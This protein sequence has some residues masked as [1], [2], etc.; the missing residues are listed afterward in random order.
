[1]DPVEAIE[2]IEACLSWCSRNLTSDEAGLKAFTGR[3]DENFAQIRADL[4]LLT[5]QR[6]VKEAYTVEEA[7]KKLG[8]AAFTVREWCRQERVHAEK[9]ACGRGQSQEWK[10]T[11]AE[12]LRIQN[13]GLLPV[14]KH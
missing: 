8:K 10:I 9:R 11:H 3:L 1:M 14:R 13:E 12:L 2:S 4:A 5:Q 7:A 6:T